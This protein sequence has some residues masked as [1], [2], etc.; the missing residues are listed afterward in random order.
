ML[1]TME[2]ILPK[3]STA[4]DELALWKE[5]AATERANLREFVSVGHVVNFEDYANPRSIAQWPDGIADNFVRFYQHIHSAEL[6]VDEVD[7]EGGLRFYPVSVMAAEL[8]GVRCWLEDDTEGYEESEWEGEL[9]LLGMPPWLDETI[10]FGGV[11]QSAERFLL[12]YGGPYRGSVLAF[13]HDP[14]GMRIAASSFEL[15]LATIIEQP[16]SVA[17]WIGLYEAVAYERK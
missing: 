16:L 12:A 17:Q 8:E 9:E 15:F 13:D 1:E 5:R 11:G 6:Y 10:V 2:L 7:P 3:G 14:L 4:S